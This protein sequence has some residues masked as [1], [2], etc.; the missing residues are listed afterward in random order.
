MSKNESLQNENHDNPETLN[1]PGLKKRLKN[2][3]ALLFLLILLAIATYLFIW[4]NGV[5]KKEIEAEKL[6]KSNKQI[7]QDADNGKLSLE[8]INKEFNRCQNFISSEEGS[9]SEFEY[10][11]NFINWAKTNFNTEESKT[12]NQ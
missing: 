1:S 2:L 7:I 6:I 11:K 12:D 10:C 8:L 9:F 4:I 5:K 3:L